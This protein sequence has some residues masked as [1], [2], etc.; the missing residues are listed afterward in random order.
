MN[1]S[2]LFTTIHQ[3]HEFRLIPLF[4]LTLQAHKKLTQERQWAQYYTQENT[5]AN[6]NPA[7]RKIQQTHR[8][9]IVNDFRLMTS[10]PTCFF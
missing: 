6:A 2:Q 8:M 3:P 5:I 10:T 4:P 7:A 9:R 1:N